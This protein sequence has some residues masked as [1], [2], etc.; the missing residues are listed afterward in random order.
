VIAN[1]KKSIHR[2]AQLAGQSD[3]RTRKSVF[4]LTE[5]DRE[6]ALAL[7]SDDPIGAVHMIGMLEDYGVI[8]AAHRGQFYGYFEN[9]KMA[10]VALLGHSILIYG[11]KA[12][13][14]YFAKAIMEAKASGHVIFGPRKQV[15]SFWTSLKKLGWQTRLVRDFH[16]FVSPRSTQLPKSLQLRKAGLEDSQVVAD[17]QAE[18]AFEVSG[19]D[20]RVSDGESFYQRVAERIRRGRVWVKI[21]DGK[22]VFKADLVNQTSETAYLEGIWTSPEYRDK[23]IATECLSELVH[24]LL[25]SGSI[26]CLVVEA[27]NE[28]AKKVYSKVGFRRQEDYQARYLNPLETS[29]S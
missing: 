9:D 11:K 26:P 25:Y 8:H 6:E 23:G 2:Q 17:A 5:A 18:M 21:E 1:L 16:W 22:L 13:L 7:L 15:E 4:K 28:A 29:V 12:S 3:R 24:R 10:G 14:P 20:P 27:H 19:I